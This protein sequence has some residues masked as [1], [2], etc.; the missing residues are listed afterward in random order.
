MREKR[1]TFSELHLRPEMVFR[2][3]A[4]EI[5]HSKYI[6]APRAGKLEKFRF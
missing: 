3:R 2:N 4:I 1:E 5:R 6:V